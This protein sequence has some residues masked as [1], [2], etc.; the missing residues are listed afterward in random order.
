METQRIN[1]IESTATELQQIIYC[2]ALEQQKISE[3]RR[4]LEDPYAHLMPN[5]SFDAL[6]SFNP[7]PCKYLSKEIR[8][9]ICTTQVPLPDIDDPITLLEPELVFEL[10]GYS[11][12]AMGSL[13]QFDHGQVEVA[14]IID[15]SSKEVQISQQFPNNVQRFTGAHELGHALL[16]PDLAGRHRDKPV[17]GLNSNQ[18]RDPKEIEADKFAAYFLMPEKLVKRKFKEHFLTDCFVLND[19]TKFALGSLPEDFEDN[20]NDIDYLAEMLAVA[21]NYNGQRRVPLAMEFKV[22][23]RAMAIRL[24]ELKLLKV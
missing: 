11:Y 18:R 22:S 24:K 4:R 3:D 2:K 13:G 9:K 6:S 17:D 20:C 1:E 7:P 12:A 10:I 15:N 14:G 19:H 16:H 23:I 5:G 8:E 21:D